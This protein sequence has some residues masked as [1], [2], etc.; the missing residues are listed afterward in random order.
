MVD[1]NIDGLGTTSDAANQADMHEV[2]PDDSSSSEL[3]VPDPG[4][5][6]KQ[7]ETPTSS[8][9]E[10]TDRYR[11]FGRR[12]MEDGRPVDPFESMTASKN[13]HRITEGSTRV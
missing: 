5:Q 13:A 8:S 9:R 4:A 12:V 3:P 1:T 10:L 6:P 2:V 7:A 11:A